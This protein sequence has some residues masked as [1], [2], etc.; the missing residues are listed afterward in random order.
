LFSL[1][2]FLF[3]ISHQLKGSAISIDFAPNSKSVE[4]WKGI[5]KYRSDFEFLATSWVKI[6]AGFRAMLL[7]EIT[8]MKTC[9]MLYYKVQKPNDSDAV[10][11]ETRSPSGMRTDGN[12]KILESESAKRES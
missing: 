11:A 3:L 1:S 6:A 9:F 4:L 10:T 2:L 7:T 5:H 8:K 12:S